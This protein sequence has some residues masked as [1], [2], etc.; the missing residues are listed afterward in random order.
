MMARENNH[1]DDVVM[2]KVM[3]IRTAVRAEITALASLV[4]YLQGTR[5][6]E[7]GVGNDL[8]GGLLVCILWVRSEDLGVCCSRSDE[9]V[10]RS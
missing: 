9:L 7:V 3:E 5:S 1:D 10:V 2:A 8:S 4:T 6:V